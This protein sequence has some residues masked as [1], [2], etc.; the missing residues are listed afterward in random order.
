[1]PTAV[2][3]GQLRQA[4]AD[5]STDR[6]RG[7]DNSDVSRLTEQFVHLNLTDKPGSAALRRMAVNEKRTARAHAVIAALYESASG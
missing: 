6:S 4:N 1:M 3:A 5:R 7:V 2:R